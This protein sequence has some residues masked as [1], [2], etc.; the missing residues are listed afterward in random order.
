MQ[1]GPK[2][3]MLK[4]VLNNRNPGPGEYEYDYMHSFS[5]NKYLQ[6]GDRSLLDK[7]DKSV[8]LRDER[9]PGPGAYPPYKPKQLGE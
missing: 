5:H 1:N 4:N 9:V 7:N 6:M 3:A 2:D 8:I